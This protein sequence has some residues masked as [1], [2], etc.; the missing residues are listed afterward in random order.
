MQCYADLSM[1]H[2]KTSKSFPHTH[3]SLPFYF[4]ARKGKCSKDNRCHAGKET[5]KT[6]HGECTAMRINFGI[7]V[8]LLAE[9]QPAYEE[10]SHQSAQ[11]NG[12]Q[13]S[14]P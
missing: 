10:A 12:R 6:S 2:I 11:S 3:T 1:L 9:G 13:S 14:P 4:S 7:N 8:K 5:Q